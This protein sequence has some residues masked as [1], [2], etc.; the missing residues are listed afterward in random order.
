MG[1]LEGEYPSDKWNHANEGMYFLGMLGF[2]DYSFS[3]EHSKKHCEAVKSHWEVERSG[4]IRYGIIF[5]ER[6]G[7]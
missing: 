2:A 3:E 1:H 4:K 7:R 5:L 6:L